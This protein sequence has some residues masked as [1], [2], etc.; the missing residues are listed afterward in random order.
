MQ[1]LSIETDGFEFKNLVSGPAPVGRILNYIFKTGRGELKHKNGYRATD[2]NNNI[3]C[4]WTTEFMI[5][6]G[7]VRLGDVVGDAVKLELTEKGREIYDLIN[8]NPTTFGEGSMPSE[9]EEVKSQIIACN[10]DLYEKYKQIFLSSLPFRILREFL[11][12]NGFHYSSRTGFMDDYFETVKLLYDANTNYN[13][14]SRTP[15]AQNRVPSLIQLCTLFDLVEDSETLEFK[16]SEITREIFEEEE[17]EYITEEFKEVD[18]KEDELSLDLDELAQ[19]YGLD[20]NVLASAVVRN[21]NLQ[22]MFKH[23]LLKKQHK[24]VVCGVANK[25][26]LIGSHIKPSASCNVLEKADSNN[27]LLLCAIHDKL[28]DRYLITFNFLSGKMV[29]SKAL[30]EEDREK[31]SL[32]EDFS[33]SE[34]LLTPERKE[35]LKEHNLSFYDKESKR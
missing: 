6:L 3:G 34:D 11:L 20:G 24:C 30:S 21:S 1:K 28:F 12:E 29:V 26:L 8:T 10:G 22:R 2:L 23:N 9:I 33:L 19:K 15:T 4:A 31:L 5:G 14:D 32:S 27:G 18:I 25:E 17:R 16:K 35:Y 7:V 13:R